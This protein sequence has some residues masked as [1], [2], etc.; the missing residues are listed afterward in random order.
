MEFERNGK[1]D[2]EAG[3]LFLDHVREYNKNLPVLM[4]SSDLNYSMSAR[5]FN[6]TFIN[7]KS[8][9]LLEKIKK[10]VMHNFGYGDFVFRNGKGETIAKAR[11][12]REF[13]TLL[14]I[15]PDD[16]LKYHADQNQFSVWLMGRGEI[17]LARKLNPI[18][19][20]DLGNDVSELR[21]MNNVILDEY[22]Q[23]KKRGK[24]LTF[25]ET[26]VLD[27]KNVVTL[28]PGSLGGKGRGLAFVNTLI[29]NINLNPY[30]DRIA[31]RT[32]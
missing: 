29:N 14:R 8:D 2:K 31:I 32:P 10:F 25:E 7:K 18:K 3:L 12:L 27:E 30:A 20:S 9:N 22:R 1:L 4:Q 28:A 24:I 26:A 13:E 21:R 16:S 6:A 11:N 15:I 5:K 23:T 17:E 19:L